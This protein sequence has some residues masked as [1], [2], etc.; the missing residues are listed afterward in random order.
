MVLTRAAVVAVI[1]LLVSLVSVPAS[2]ADYTPRDGITFNN[3]YGNQAQ[4]NAILS[5]IIRSIRATPRG[6][7]IEI[8]SWNFNSREAVNALARAQ[9]RNVQVRFL[10]ARGNVAPRGGDSFDQLKRRLAAGNEGRPRSERSWVRACRQSCR[11]RGGAAHAK[12]FLFSESGSA[13][14]VV[15]QGSANLTSTSGSNQWNDMQTLTGRPGPYNFVRGVFEQMAK[16]RPVRNTYVTWSSGPDKLAFFPGA[17]GRN[18]DPVMQLLN[19]VRCAGATNTGNGRTRIRIAPDVIREDRGMRLARKVRALWVNGC[20]V[21]IGYTVMGVDA[22]RMLRQPSRRGPVPLAHMVRDTNGDGQFDDYFH[23]KSV[24]ITGNVRGKSNGYAVLN[25]SQ[26][27]SD[28][29][30]RS[31]ENVGVFYREG[32]TKQYSAHIDRWYQ[33]FSGGNAARYAVARQATA[34]GR[35]VDGFLF[36]TGPVGGVDPYAQVEMD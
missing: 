3:A 1:A 22:G 9:Q 8:M 4:Q 19:Q 15:M 20:D 28:A 24:A 10:Q 34:D 33:R 31:D 30:A 36:G 11:G 2:S 23:M 14:Q 18:P 27:W 25:G 6:G 21:R 13:D 12:F 26:N 16:D 35:L 17:S 29:S 5:K 7:E 32:M